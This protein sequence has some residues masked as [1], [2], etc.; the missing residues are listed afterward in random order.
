[1]KHLKTA[2]VFLL[3][4]VAWASATHVAVLETVADPS[5]NE[6]VKR[7]ERQFLTNLLRGE[8][9]KQLP[10]EHYTIMTR[11]NIEAM[12]PPGKTIEDCEGTC[13][14]ETGRNIAADYVCQ[15][16]VSSFGDALSLSVELYETA[17]NNLVATINERGAN[18]DELEKIIKLKAPAFFRKI[19]G[20]STGFSDVGGISDVSSDDSFSFSGSNQ[21]VVEIVTEPAGAVPTIDG[22]ASTRCL[23][24]PCKVQIE[25]GVH[26]I[27]AS[28]DR[29]IDADVDVE[30][31]ANN[32][33]VEL[34]LEPKF[35]YLEL[36]PE[37]AGGVEN[38]GMLEA[39]VDGIREYGS[40]VELA[41]GEHSVR[42]NHPCYNPVE[43]KVTIA[44]NKT[45]VFD[46]KM[47]RGK[48]GLKLDAE[49][50]NSP[51]VVSVFADGEKLGSTPYRGEVPLCAEIVL[52]GDRWD[53]S[54]DVELK[55]H[56]TVEVVHQ[57]SLLPEDENVIED[58]N[59]AEDEVRGKAEAAYDELDGK[60]G[61]TMGESVPANVE[62]SKGGGSARWIV[63]GVSAAVAITGV[64][65][66][67]V[68]E[69]T[70]MDA[71]DRGG[72]T[73]SELEKNRDDAEFGQTLR[74][75][76]LGLS[77]VGAIGV[78]VSFAF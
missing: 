71:A 33:K 40:K 43:F 1:M 37:L 72:K 69:N 26:H 68:G 27:V 76:G 6:K 66:A 55:W 28:M 5:V 53:E 61:A 8:A 13:L 63:L 38:R 29:Y 44:R 42:L 45:E 9:I 22:K 64:A 51:E 74:S 18:V 54:V 46:K 52:K 47:S 77:L 3:S 39:F 65:L 70:A 4:F 50:R 30:I 12:L 10:A 23:S 60:S 49:Y 78:G 59:L 21:Y 19:R 25:E 11:E 24:T 73:V 67:I 58:E 16:H 7:S 31:K 34:T 36:R 41:P 15:A 35:G 32:Q 57:L 17:K 14:V 20:N 75:V 2:F 48:G 62:S 56:E